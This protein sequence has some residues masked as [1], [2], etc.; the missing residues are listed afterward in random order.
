MDILAMSVSMNSEGLHITFNTHQS[1]STIEEALN[2]K[3]DMNKL[4]SWHHPFCFSHWPIGAGS[5]A[6]EW[7][8]HW[9]RGED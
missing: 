3:E 9:G 6:H 5:W 1:V 4:L 8:V 2:N 7:S